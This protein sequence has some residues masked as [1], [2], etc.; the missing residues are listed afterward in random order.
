MNYPINATILDIVFII[1]TILLLTIGYIKGFVIRLY[2]F[3]AT[4]V[5]LVLSLFLSGPLSDIF[6]LYATSGILMLIGSFVNRMFVFGLLFSLFRLLFFILGKFVKPTIRG[7]VSR[8]SF[9]NKFDHIL[10]VVLSFIEALVISYI[11][12]LIS[13]SPIFND[14]KETVNDT[15]V[16][17]HVLQIA[18]T[19]SN[20]VMKMTDDFRSINDIIG[21]GVNYDYTSPESISLMA[22]LL[23]GIQDFHLL[24]SDEMDELINTYV[25]ALDHSNQQIVVDEETYK[26]I[27]ELINTMGLPN[28]NAEKIYEK[29]IVSE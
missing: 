5:A 23:S 12:L 16:A 21:Q 28:N 3:V 6:H 7:V 18:P 17:K 29:I 1:F 22:S 11:V 26:A 13:V 10:G 20:Q 4:F 8:I 14:G 19:L 24:S 15:M 2:D 25:E 27:Q 9:I